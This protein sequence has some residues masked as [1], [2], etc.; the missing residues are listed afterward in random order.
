[1]LD[2]Q[3][4]ALIEIV[5]RRQK[6]QERVLQVHKQQSETE[7]KYTVEQERWINFTNHAEM[8]EVL[9]AFFI[10]LFASTVEPQALGT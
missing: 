5:Q 8:P 1:M 4:S 7:G 2:K 10:F 6:P 9:K 3:I